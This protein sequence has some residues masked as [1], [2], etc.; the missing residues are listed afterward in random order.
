MTKRAILALALLAVTLG[1]ARGGPPKPTG[2][3][4]SLY[5][6]D[7]AGDLLG[8][9]V[10]IVRTRAGL[11]GTFQIAEGEP[12]EL[13]LIPSIAVTGDSVSFTIPRP[14][15][16]AGTFTG[17]LTRSGLKGTLKY[18]VRGGLELDLARKASYWE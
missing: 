14:S 16:Y 9:E 1:A 8:Q 15:P 6:H 18:A 2:T 11:Q 17:R 12:S 3:F 13:V 7:E 5:W 4:T 10:H